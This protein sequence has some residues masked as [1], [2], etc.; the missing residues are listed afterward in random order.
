MNGPKGEIG[1]VLMANVAVLSLLLMDDIILED[2]ICPITQDDN[3]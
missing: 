3:F 1:Y 2:A